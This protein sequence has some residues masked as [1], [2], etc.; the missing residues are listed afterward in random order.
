MPVPAPLQKHAA[1]AAVS[2]I[3]RHPD[4]QEQPLQQSRGASGGLQ[5]RRQGRCRALVGKWERN[6][7]RKL[8]APGLAFPQSWRPSRRA[9]GGG[10]RPGWLGAHLSGGG[11]CVRPLCS[12]LGVLPSPSSL[13]FTLGESK[14]LI[15]GEKGVWGACIPAPLCPQT[16]GLTTGVWG[17]GE[18]SPECP[19]QPSLQSP[20]QPH[21][22]RLHRQTA[23][24]W[25]PPSPSHQPSS[26][27]AWPAR[28]GGFSC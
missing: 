24:M 7:E 3:W 13:V 26:S 9:A 23:Q 4:F 20:L 12:Y 10:C 18:S 21:L 14:V 6:E 15:R 16:K 5:R 19:I 22:R 8:A 28:D 17:R 2:G 1:G 11:G 25:T 27:R